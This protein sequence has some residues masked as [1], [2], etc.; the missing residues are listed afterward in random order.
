MD[1]PSSTES[2]ALNLRIRFKSATLEEF[3]GR[4][5]VDV[6]PGGIFV[7]TKQPV[8]VGTTLRFDF[9]LADGSSLLAGLGTVAWVRENDPSR[10]NNVPGMG[11]RFDKLTPESQHIHQ[12]ILA[13]KARKEGK[14]QATPY[15]PTA[16]VAPAARQAPE[17]EPVTAAR[18][19]PVLP[20][21]ALPQPE[22]SPANFAKT[23]P[24]P[25]AALAARMQESAGD[26]DEFETG[27]KTE[28]SDKPLDYY[29][30][31]AEA[32][33]RGEVAEGLVPSAPLD[34]WKTDSHDLEGAGA[35]PAPD[36]VAIS[37]SQAY[38]TEAPAP[39]DLT[40]SGERR[41]SS[42]QAF[43]ALLDLGDT[44]EN[45]AAAQPGEA[46]SGVPVEV[47]TSDKTEEVSVSP[48][49]TAE[50]SGEAIY[51]PRRPASE[52]ESEK[53]PTLAEIDAATVAPRGK[54]SSALAVG[55]VLLAGGAA[56][57]A[58]YLL[59]KKPWQTAGEPEAPTVLV[60]KT[61]AVTAKATAEPAPAVAAAPAPGPAAARVEK[62]A[63]P[64]EAPKPASGEE[65]VAKKA[66]GAAGTP[67][68]PAPPAEKA[69]AT[70]AAVGKPVAERPAPEKPSARKP[71]SAKVEAP[72]AKATPRPAAKATPRPSAEPAAAEKPAAAA[73]EQEEIFRLSFRSSPIGAEVLIDGEYFA[74]TPCER[75][76]LDPKKTMA[77]TIRKEG[78]E[79]HERM[80]GSSA[81]WAKKGNERILS[82]YA[83]LKKSAQKPASAPSAV[84]KPAPAAPKP[85]AAGVGAADPPENE[86]HKE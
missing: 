31:E 51:L 15:P 65:A 14:G 67:V 83:V 23:L 70:K 60:K 4:Y 30:R 5:G 24:A 3:I 20:P 63:A 52:E 2:N 81:N 43:A 46:D 36:E 38:A 11:L 22:P 75:R 19:A 13:E 9:A 40:A 62:A 16:F 33:Q 66:T 73:T 50:E 12:T 32:A 76:I 29:M 74:R 86:P 8:E 26:A 80:V 42:K 39:T 69:A 1:Q 85:A 58:V 17:P 48:A 49:K 78:Y 72:A 25:A 55:A 59:Q 79:A 56:F 7:R 37:D 41:I 53:V 10:T 34:G 61:P 21:E 45:P 28:I 35:P 54:R 47:T 82:I 57:A 44:S 68:A 18:E 64:A 71:V 77:I 84:A 27:G 6:S